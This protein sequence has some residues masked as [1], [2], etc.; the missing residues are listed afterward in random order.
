[1][2]I[3]IRIYNQFFTFLNIEKWAFYTIN[4]HSPDG[5]TAV[6]LSDTA[7]YT[8]AS[9]GDT[10][11]ALAEFALSGCLVCDSAMTRA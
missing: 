9:Q 2:L 4:C 11:A 8:R 7:L 10:A 6:A 5:D 1:V 3:Q